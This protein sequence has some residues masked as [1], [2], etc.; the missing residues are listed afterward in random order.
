MT[1]RVVHIITGLD[2]G[3]AEIAL[4][5]LLAA[6]PINERQQQRVI[7]LIPLGPMAQETIKLGVQVDSLD[8]P[9]G[10]PTPRGLFKLLKI[11]RHERNSLLQGW[12]YHGNL[13]ATIAALFLFRTRHLL[14]YVH[15]S[16]VPMD[17]EKRLTRFVIRFSSLLS[18]FPRRIIYVAERSAHQHE[19]IGYSRRRTL[20]IPNGYNIALFK[21]DEAASL[22]LRTELGL[23]G[24]VPLIGMIGRW[25]WSKDHSNFLAALA[26]VPHAHAVLIGKNVEADNIELMALIQAHNLTNRVHLLGY[27]SDIPSL[28]PGLDLLCLS[29]CTEAMPNVVGEAMASGVPCVVTDVGAAAEMVGD[30]GW[31]CP[32]RDPERLAAALAQA[33]KS[34]LKE[35][36]QRARSRLEARYVQQRVNTAFS[37][38]Y[39]SLAAKK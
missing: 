8:M 21:P 19:A 27:R 23:T 25:D 3:G 9:P 24:E 37:Q 6:L 38:L 17:G 15:G 39:E 2:V 10:C 29:S 11:L 20:I 30:T 36:G 35:H 22:R 4:Y 32:P 1:M 33:L 16:L 7:S 12:M 28:M 34:D 26:Q 5:N 18:R 31:V 13:V 14:W